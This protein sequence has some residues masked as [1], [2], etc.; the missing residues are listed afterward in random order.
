MIYKF[1]KENI[2]Y[3][4]LTIGLMVGMVLFVGKVL[5][6]VILSIR[7]PNEL[8]EPSNVALTRMF[9][10]GKCP[11]VKSS[12]EY[13]IP[14]ISYEYP[15]IGSLVSALI[16]LC[17]GKNVVLAHMI[18]SFAALVGTGILGYKIINLYSSTT[19]A[20]VAGAFLFMLCHWRF[21]FVSA[22]PDDLGLFLLILTM[23]LAVSPKVTNKPIVCAILTTICF[24]TKQYFVFVFFGIC[25]YMFLYS[26]KDA[27][28]YCIETIVINVVAGVIVT[29]VWPL[30]WS[31]TVFF[32]Y[33]GCS[34]GTGFGIAN[35]IGQ[36]K[37]LLAIFVLLF[38]V[39]LAAF[40]VFI[41]K[42]RREGRKLTTYE[43]SENDP[44]V[45]FAVQI[46]VMFLP[47]IVFGRNDGAFLSYFL[48]LWMPSI[49]V[50]TF[51][52]LEKIQVNDRLRLIF[53]GFYAF[54]IA[55]TV[56]FGYLKLPIHVITA[57]EI[58]DWERAYD[59]VN[60]SREKGD[61]CYSQQLAYLAFENDDKY[62]FCGHDGEVSLDTLAIWESSKLA[63]ILF[64]YVD[65]I[66]NK[67]MD[68]RIE[69][70]VKAF[71]S[72]FELITFQNDNSLLFNEQFI[73][74]G[75]YY[76]RLDRIPLQE[77]NMAYTVSFYGVNHE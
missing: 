68:Y 41:R 62:Y 36:M 27:L 37:Y 8:L 72:G 38:G 61:V 26:K 6:N 54:V 1:K 4:L 50:V 47:L 55:F 49:I 7:Y 70:I 71:E 13:E 76:S 22:A 29:I 9:L 67:N 24:Y 20:P 40:V 58:A 53:D 3:K 31:Y 69:I 51:I 43:F 5:T 48:Q 25:V 34:T 17:I 42:L 46:P 12:L 45:L 39:V 28:K 57:Q 66:I 73:D 21:G 35:L 10:D 64:P 11:Y 2:I 63:Q 74:E 32:L 33:F 14:A 19:V 77:G 15:F 56:L 60:T 52:V 65:D 16:A 75:V 59:I 18:V 30:Y 44:L 23:Y